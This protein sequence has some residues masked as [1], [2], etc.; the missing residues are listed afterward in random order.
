MSPLLLALDLGTTTLAG[1]IL[2]AQGQ[3]LAEGKVVNP[4]RVLGA[5][6]VRRLEV[7][8]A[9]EGE[10]L[11]ALLIDGIATLFDDLLRSAGAGRASIGAA[12]AAANPGVTALLGGDDV[13]PILFPPHRPRQ[14][15]LRSLHLPAL[16]LPVPLTVFPLL[17]GYVGGDL[18]ACLY[19]LTSVAGRTLVIDLGT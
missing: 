11:Q 3:V 7:A 1:R 6:I 13:R 19:G 5:D 4:Q 10:R 8:L 18:I 15:S 9:G 12:A 14:L 17:S 16:Q 2:D